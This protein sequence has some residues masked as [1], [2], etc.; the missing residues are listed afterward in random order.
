VVAAHGGSIGVQDTDGGGA[1]FR[2][3]LPLP[4]PAVRVPEPKP[5]PELTG[6]SKQTLGAI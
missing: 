2:I 6:D 5:E 3:E 1:T 4:D